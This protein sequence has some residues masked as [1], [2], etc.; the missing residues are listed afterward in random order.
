MISTR[1]ALYTSFSLPKL[2]LSLFTRPKSSQ[3]TLYKPQSRSADTY[4][5]PHP[6]HATIYRYR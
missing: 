5:N 4:D 3:K 1:P 6:E 2:S